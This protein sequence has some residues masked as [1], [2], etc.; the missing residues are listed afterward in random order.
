MGSVDLAA[1]KNISNAIVTRF[2]IHFRVS[3]RELSSIN[4]ELRLNVLELSANLL[5]CG[6]GANSGLKKLVR[7]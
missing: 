7:H 2:V 4:A 3:Y 6:N 5:E 1:E